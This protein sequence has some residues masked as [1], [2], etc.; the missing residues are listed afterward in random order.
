MKPGPISRVV[1]GYF[2]TGVVNKNL[3]PQKDRFFAVTN[4]VIFKNILLHRINN[5]VKKIDG[6]NL[7]YNRM[8]IIKTLSGL[9]KLTEKDYIYISPLADIFF[10]EKGKS[11]PNL[12]LLN[13]GLDIDLSLGKGYTFK[14]MTYKLQYLNSFN[15]DSNYYNSQAFVDLK[16][17][18]LLRHLDVLNN[19]V[20]SLEFYRDQKD[21]NKDVIDNPLKILDFIKDIHNPK[22]KVSSDFVKFE[23]QYFD[24]SITFDNAPGFK[25][26][27]DFDKKNKKSPISFD[28]GEKNIFK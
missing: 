1:R 20:K 8:K 12:R 21:S 25:P 19:L 2:S 3:L 24:S 23:D 4:S 5:I 22:Y 15:N 6:L 16:L 18:T 27:F 7:I 17:D 14:V 11:I 9:E 26:Q 13:Q 10:V 28:F